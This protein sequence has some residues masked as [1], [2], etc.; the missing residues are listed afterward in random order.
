[1]P[2]VIDLAGKRFG[3]LLV[4]K[5]AGINKQGFNY[6][7]CKCDCGNEKEII[8]SNL[9]RGQTKSC[10]CSK[11]TGEF[12]KTHGMRK[13]RFY[14]IWCA[15]KTRCYNAKSIEYENYGGRG[16]KVCE[17]WKQFENFFKDMHNTYKDDLTI[18]RINVNGDYCK[19]NCKWSTPKEQGNN[20][21][22]NKYYTIDGVTDTMSNLCEKYKL[23]YGIVKNRIRYGWDIEKAFK[24][25]LTKKRR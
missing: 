23:G 3:K 4:I 21:R 5:K 18:D 8:S 15:I 1:M 20:K 19:E 14:R 7:L 13:T 25:P 17:S 11:Y 16:I 10:G 22:Y 2:K 9:L 24:T 6:W 12:T